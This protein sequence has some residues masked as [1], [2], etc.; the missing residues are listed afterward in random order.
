MHVY[1]EG[2][3]ILNKKIAILCFVFFIICILLKTNVFASTLNIGINA[4]K[5]NYNIGE[6]IKIRVSWSEGMQAAGFT[7]NYDSTKVEFCSASISSTFY[8]SDTKG[9]Y[10]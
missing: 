10:L 3:K 4:D 2:K 8:N 1:G 5:Q 9:K 7:L 6:Q